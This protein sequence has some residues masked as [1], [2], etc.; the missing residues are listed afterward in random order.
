MPWDCNSSA[1]PAYRCDP[2][3]P[4][5][6]DDAPQTSGVLGSFGF[7]GRNGVRVANLF[8]PERSCPIGIT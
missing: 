6:V 1:M 3:A 4:N 2:R 7:D 5:I 8:A